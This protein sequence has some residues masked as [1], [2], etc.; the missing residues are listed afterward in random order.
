MS[1]ISLDL[2]NTRLGQYELLEIIGRGSAATVY[3]AYQPALNRHVAIKL[4]RQPDAVGAQRFRREAQAV[5]ALH[6]PNILPIYDY[7]EQDGLLYFVTQ[8]V[9]V[10]ERGEV[11][12]GDLLAGEPITP[13]AALQLMRELL[14]GLGYAH[15]RGVIHRDIKPSNILLPSLDWPLLAD[16][17]IAQLRDAGQ[18]TG[19]GQ[20]MGTAIYLAPERANGQPADARSDLYAA[21]VVLYELLTGQA[22]FV[23][24]TPAAVVAQQLHTPPPSPRQLNPTIPEH[25]EAVLL[26]AL[27]KAP[28]ARYQRAED[29]A[30]ALDTSMREIE[31]DTLLAELLQPPASYTTRKLTAEAGQTYSAPLGITAGARTVAHAQ[32]T[33]HAGS[34]NGRQ[35]RITHVG[36][37]ILLFVVLALLGFLLGA[38]MYSFFPPY[39]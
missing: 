31:H 24:H 28:D 34:A 30:A 10:N 27:A 26:R 21:G 5:A 8:Y 29:L 16:F 15:A 20:I 19:P 6:H 18:L 11:T 39:M 7:G 23:G 3:K 32:Q 14:A 9:G 36:R 22:P 2:S 33:P 35:R 4:L 25:L 37:V 13:V 17:G 12:L 38:A 1:A